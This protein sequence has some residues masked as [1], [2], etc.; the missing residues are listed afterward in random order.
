MA[1]ITNLEID[2]RLNV[3]QP[4]LRVTSI[5][6]EN[7]KDKAPKFIYI[8]GQIWK[9]AKLRLLGNIEWTNNFQ[10]FLIFGISI[11]FHIEKILKT[12]QFFRL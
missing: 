5:E 6:N 11:V 8:I 4:N 2:E 9:S 7:W 1:N 10:N 3:E 12:R